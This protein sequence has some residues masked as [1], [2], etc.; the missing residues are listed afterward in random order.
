VVHGLSFSLHL[1]PARAFSVAGGLLRSLASRIIRKDECR[2]TLAAD[3][4]RVGDSYI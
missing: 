3:G 4:A 1:C 2:F